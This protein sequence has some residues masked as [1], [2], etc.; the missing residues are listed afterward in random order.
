MFRD[1]KCSDISISIIL[2]A[3]VLAGIENNEEIFLKLLKRFHF[4]SWSKQRFF[5]Y[6]TKLSKG[7]LKLLVEIIAMNKDQFHNHELYLLQR[8]FKQYLSVMPALNFEI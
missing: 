4:E 3:R 6:Q 1:Q 7:A 2:C 5:G 8:Q